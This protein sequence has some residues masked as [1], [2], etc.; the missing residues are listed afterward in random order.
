[1]FCK[2]VA[3]GFRAAQV[4]GRWHGEIYLA[5]PQG[6]MLDVC[7]FSVAAWK[8]LPGS[9]SAVQ[10]VL[11]TQVPALVNLECIARSSPNGVAVNEVVS[12]E[13]LAPVATFRGD[14]GKLGFVFGE[15]AGGK[16]S[17]GASESDE[18]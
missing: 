6:A 18:I 14:D 7:G 16:S 11:A 9:V 17:V 2:V 13:I 5:T 15:K 10:G 4:A 8:I 3:L 1:M 12:A